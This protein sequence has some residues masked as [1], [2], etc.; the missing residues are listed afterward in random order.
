MEQEKSY[1]DVKG[2]TQIGKTPIRSK[3]KALYDGGLSRSSVEHPVMGEEQR[4][5]VIQMTLDLSTSQGRKS[6]TVDSKVIP[7]TTQMV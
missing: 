5:G 2:K 6:R 4:A 1:R 3:T 7:I